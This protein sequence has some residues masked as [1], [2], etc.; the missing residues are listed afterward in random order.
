MQE[1]TDGAGAPHQP[2]G[3]PLTASPLDKPAMAILRNWYAGRECAVCRREIGPVQGLERRLGLLSVAAPAHEILTWE[4][5]PTDQLPGLLESHLPVCAGCTLAESF[6][7]QF[8]DR[9]TDRADTAAR[10]RAFH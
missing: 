9:V 7:R 8:P 6:R 2:S 5:I 1:R 4:E 3:R 10:D